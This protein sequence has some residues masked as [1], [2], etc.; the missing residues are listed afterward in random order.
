MKKSFI[1]ICAL[2]LLCALCAQAQVILNFDAS[3]TSQLTD[4]DYFANYLA[5]NTYAVDPTY[6]PQLLQNP[7]YQQTVLQPEAS[8]LQMQAMNNAASKRGNY[9]GIATWATTAT[10]DNVSLT[11]ADGSALYTT[12]FAAEGDE[13]NKNGGTWTFADGTLSQTDANDLGSL[14]VCYQLTGHDATLQLDATKTGGAEGFLIAFSYLDSENYTWWNIGGWG[15]SQHAIEQ[16]I[17]GQKSLLATAAGSIQTGQTYRLKVEMRGDHVRCYID[18]QLIHDIQFDNASTLYGAASISDDASRV[19]VRISNPS[20]TAQDVVVRLKDAAVQSAQHQRQTLSTEFSPSTLRNLSVG[21]PQQSALSPVLT[22]AMR[23]S[24][25]ARS[26]NTLQLAVADVP[27][28]TAIQD[29]SEEQPTDT[30]SSSSAAADGIYDLTG[31][32]YAD[33][34]TLP[35]GLYIVGGRKLLLR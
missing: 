34:H 13:W 17:D 12:D 24:V 4:D 21:T 27:V 7:F 32:R 2:C 35:R 3:Q 5:A 15:N 16:C 23:F 19:F 28:P 8:A 26:L 20:A 14:M 9:F 25:P 10:F 31:R 30:L 6:Y 22:S 33:T 11:T 18:D 1:L 29:L